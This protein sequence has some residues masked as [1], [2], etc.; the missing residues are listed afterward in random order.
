MLNPISTKAAL[1]QQALRSETS[2]PVTKKRSYGMI[3]A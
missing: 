2:V 1:T 3:N